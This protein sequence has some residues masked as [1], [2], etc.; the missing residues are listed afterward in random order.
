MVRQREQMRTVIGRWWTLLGG[1][2]LM[3][4]NERELYRA[5]QDG[6]RQ[7]AYFLLAVTVAAIAFAV[8]QTRDARLAVEHAPLA[9]AVVLWGWSFY[10]ACR[11]LQSANA[12]LYT[13]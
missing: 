2:A 12:S 4:D 7:Y 11:H 8:N 13:A 1:S 5:H 10:L 6:L 3:V 9:V